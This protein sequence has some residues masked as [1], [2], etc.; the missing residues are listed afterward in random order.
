MVEVTPSTYCSGG[1]SYYI[2]KEGDCPFAL[3]M[4]I[5][6]SVESDIDKIKL[7]HLSKTGNS[8]SLD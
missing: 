1:Y 2:A 4:I 8:Y 7:D 3:L 6:E 5:Q